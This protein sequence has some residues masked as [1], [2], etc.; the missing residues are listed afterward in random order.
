M[1]HPITRTNGGLV[2]SRIYVPLV[3]DELNKSNVLTEYVWGIIL[4]DLVGVQSELEIWHKS[5][6]KMAQLFDVKMQSI[7]QRVKFAGVK[8]CRCHNSYLKGVWE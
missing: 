3:L 5:A 2:Y 8:Q 7:A 4:L 1:R 6:I